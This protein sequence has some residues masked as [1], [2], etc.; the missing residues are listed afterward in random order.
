MVDPLPPLAL[1]TVSLPH[2]VP[3]LAEAATQLGVALADVDE[4]FGLVPVDPEKGLYAVQ[5]RADKLPSETQ[6]RGA[7]FRGPWSNPSIEPLSP[8]P[9]S[10]A[11]ENRKNAGP[12]SVDE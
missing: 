9:S 12:H 11:V 8:T 2:A 1:M 4:T 5:V 7:G 10:D 3:S 6:D